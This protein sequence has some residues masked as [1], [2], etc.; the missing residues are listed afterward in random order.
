MDGDAHAAV[1]EPAR[2][3][4][5]DHDLLGPGPYGGVRRGAPREGSAHDG[6]CP[7]RIP[8]PLAVRRDR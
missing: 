3:P 5:A 6:P 4:F 8:C 7:P 1:P 2:R